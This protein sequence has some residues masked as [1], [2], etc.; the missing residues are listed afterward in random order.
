MTKQRI[1]KLVG[2]VPLAVCCFLLQLAGAA[3]EDDST[4]LPGEITPEAA[5]A[6]EAGDA[7]QATSH[8]YVGAKKCFICHRPETKT[9]SESEHARP[10][11]DVLG[12]YHDDPACQK[13][14]VTGFGEPSGFTA[15]TDKDLHLVGCESCHGPGSGHI[16]AA[17]RFVLAMPGEEDQ[18]AQEMR[19]AI[20]KS[21]DDATCMQCHQTQAHQPHPSYAGQTTEA[22]LGRPVGQCIP[23]TAVASLPGRSVS[24]YSI[25]T[26]GGCHYDQ[27]KQWSTGGHADLAA[28]LSA[29]HAS[30]PTCQGCHPAA[31][32]TAITLA[33][34]GQSIEDVIG[35]ACENC[36][37]PGLGHI[38][39]N[40]QFVACP[41][42]GR[43]LEQAARDSIRLGKPTSTCV[44][45]HSAQGHKVHPA[46]EEK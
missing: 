6:A 42:L 25:K 20:I 35:A 22:I 43:Q 40:K 30:D 17:E 37:G 26:C 19:D 41:P 44:K 38:N 45:C 14:H 10:A 23:A 18:I 12:G 31:G 36:H 24:R 21:P 1:R 39:F 4:S 46:I 11:A 27:Y 32:Q 15:N 29:S 8:E 9:W 3:S 33:A 2:V 7:V 5:A 13:C 34:N 28:K 16:A